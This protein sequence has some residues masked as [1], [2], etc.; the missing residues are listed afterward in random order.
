MRL[1]KLHG[2]LSKPRWTS[3]APPSSEVPLVL[4]WCARPWRS[5]SEDEKRKAEFDA[6]G[7]LPPHVS[8]SSQT[9]ACAS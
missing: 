6:L 1:K 3:K 9:D 2:T 4:E 5:C 8:V 7:P